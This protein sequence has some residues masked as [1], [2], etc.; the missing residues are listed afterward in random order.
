MAIPTLVLRTIKGSALTYQEMDS[1]FQNLANLEVAGGS[2]NYSN[3]NVAAYLTSQSITSYSNVQVA[4][5]LTTNPPAGTYS[6]VQVGAYLTTNPPAGTYSNV[7]VANYLPTYG[8]NVA[9]LRLGV[10]G[11]LTFSDGTRMITASAGGGSGIANVSV[12]TAPTLGGNLNPN[13]FSITANIASTI[14]TN[15]ETKSVI[16]FENTDTRE[17]VA[18]AIS[19]LGKGNSMTLGVLGN[20]PTVVGFGLAQGSNFIQGPFGGPV[21]DLWFLSYGNIYT[22]LGTRISTNGIALDAGKQVTID[23][24]ALTSYS[25]VE[26][27]SYLTAN[28]PA[29]TYSNVQVATYLPTYTGNIANV[30]LGASG[31]LTFADGTT[32]TTA[33]AGG[34]G[35]ANVSADTTPSLGGNLNVNNFSITGNVF[36]KGIRFDF[37]TSSTSFWEFSSAQS[38][39]TFY[40]GDNE[41]ANVEFTANVNS[42]ADVDYNILKLQNLS[43]GSNAETKMVLKASA[44]TNGR[45]L[46]IF[47][48]SGLT[49]YS[50][51]G[52]PSAVSG[53]GGIYNI[54]GNLKLYA[55]DDSLNPAYI[56][57]QG[58][59]VNAAS[60]PFKFNLGTGDLNT[61]GNIN[62]AAGKGV[63]V[64]GVALSGGGSGIANVSVDTTPTL[65]GNLNVNNKTIT[66]NVFNKGI[67]FSFPAADT[68]SSLKFTSTAGL[69]AGGSAYGSIAGVAYYCGT[70]ENTS[71][72]LTANNNTSHPQFKL[73]NISTGSFSEAKIVLFDSGA[74]AVQGELGIFKPSGNTYSLGVSGSTKFGD[75]G[76][77]NQGG[78]L[79]LYAWDDNTNPKHITFQGLFTSTAADEPFDFDLANGDLKTLGNINLAAGKNVYLNGVAVNAYG[80]TQVTSVLAGN[81]T[82]GNV[83]GKTSG[84]TLGYLEMPQVTAANVTLALTDSGKHFYDTSTAPITITIPTNAN[85]AFPIGTVVS[86]VNGSTGNLIVDKGSVTLYLGGNATSASRTITSYGV[87][88]LM[89]VATDTWFI[90]GSG[91]V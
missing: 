80:N 58:L 77:Y 33:N 14:A 41:I 42:G 69:P 55:S 8:G 82:V 15:S 46:G 13:G 49:G 17:N 12:D 65:G 63:Y 53:D 37:G 57:F 48:P 32:Q 87:A 47:K 89:K 35:I 66:G 72:M 81:I 5:Y 45:E 70:N 6:N 75:G 44:A 51:A 24:V 52:V 67:E 4:S 31:I 85:V 20:D 3:T 21:C 34:G 25:N 64:N 16:R 60:E 27:A 2:S 29:G 43:N 18:S 40:C 50:Y 68:T 28:P 71:L 23:G 9:N 7:Q 11:G 26:V 74:Y 61:L 59:T 22:G 62:L 83:A 73:Q 54:G 91:V 30:R 1:N 88:T 36:N 76:I 90:N 38:G 10:S 79:K 56:T 39:Q 19:I 86:A 84:F 78:N